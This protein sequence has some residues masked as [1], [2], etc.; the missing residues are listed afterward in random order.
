MT[1]LVLARPRRQLQQVWEQHQ[2]P[3]DSR[4]LYAARVSPHKAGRG[5]R[6]RGKQG[7]LRKWPYFLTSVQPLLEAYS[8]VQS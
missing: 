2:E 5:G 4:P 3:W 1:L 8:R 7:F 6:Q